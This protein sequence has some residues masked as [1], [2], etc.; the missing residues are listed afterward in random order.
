MQMSQAV[1]AGGLFTPGGTDVSSSD[2]ALS[3]T[4]APAADFEQ[5]MQQSG[6]GQGGPSRRT[7]TPT[8]TAPQPVATSVPAGE[9]P[10]LFHQTTPAGNDPS[11]DAGE[12]WTPLSA[13]MELVANAMSAPVEAELEFTGDALTEVAP[14]AVDS[15][16]PEVLAAVSQLN[17]L[18]PPPP[19]SQIT[20]ATCETASDP[21]AETPA[22]TNDS[23]PASGG[24]AV[25]RESPSLQAA[26]STDRATNR[27]VDVR[28]ADHITTRRSSETEARRPVET[29]Q[30]SSPTTIQATPAAHR[31]TPEPAPETAPVPA[32]PASPRP[33]PELRPTP[34]R[35]HLKEVEEMPG[36]VPSRGEA[37][38]IRQRVAVEGTTQRASELSRFQIEADPS[39]AVSAAIYRR[40]NLIP[41]GGTAAAKTA[42]SMD[43]GLEQNHFA[44]SAEQNLPARGRT[45][46][47]TDARSLVERPVS[48]VHER[49]ADRSDKAFTTVVEALTSRPAV[50][51]LPSNGSTA[52][53]EAAS[54]GTAARTAEQL[55]QNVSREVAQFKRFNAESMAVVLKPDSHTEIFLHLASRNGQIEIQARFERGDFASL[56]GQWTQLQQTLSQ[57]GVR[58][59]NLQEGFNQ[60]S[61]QPGGGA[62]WGH[63][64]M[65]H[66]QQRQAGRDP[67]D[68]RQRMSFD[69]LVS[70]GSPAEAARPS[71]RSPAAVARANSVLEAWA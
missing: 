46:P 25:H 69:E 6:E 17:G 31:N 11:T 36:S 23:N 7:S 27:E 8:P 61:Q 42:L 19:P 51:N 37:N 71:R 32:D 64:Q 70:R 1:S 54:G 63:G 14:P 55:L 45:S 30:V 3:Q 18:V 12:N 28:G 4:Q 22:S 43:K 20:T 24:G 39:A 62:D 67:D 10:Q 48:L 41:A 29:A 21:E 40:A 60:A 58:L 68:P 52:G 65:N 9:R 5:H 33:R 53:V 34:V 47:A 49:A 56:N 35:H 50:T 26:A 15:P 13:Q 44:G 59:S 2:P 38:Q 57:Q 16:P 66:G